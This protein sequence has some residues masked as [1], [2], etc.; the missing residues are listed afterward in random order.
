MFIKK[1]Q[2]KCKKMTLKGKKYFFVRKILLSLSHLMRLCLL[3]CASNI[4][5][6][7]LGKA[8]FKRSAFYFALI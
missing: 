7:S 5:V 3:L 1:K 2:M 8:D 4:I 6:T